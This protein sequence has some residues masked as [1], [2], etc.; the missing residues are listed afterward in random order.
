MEFNEKPE[1]VQPFKVDLSE[2]MNAAE[3]L[4]GKGAKLVHPCD[5]FAQRAGYDSWT[6][7]LEAMK[8]GKIVTATGPAIGR[9]TLDFDMFLDQIHSDGLTM[10][11]PRHNEF[12]LVSV[13]LHERFPAA[14]L[15][16]VDR[17]SVSRTL[18]TQFDASADPL[19]VL[20]RNAV[21]RLAA[22]STLVTREIGAAETSSD[23]DKQ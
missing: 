22:N 12:G 20:V 23:K 9:T 2:S 19:E 5:A 14:T 21:N 11:S 15:E 10:V 13:G 3:V 6:A 7:A 4:F 17:E 18:V 8:N 16:R 1:S